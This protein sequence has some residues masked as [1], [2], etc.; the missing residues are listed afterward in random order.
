MIRKATPA[1]A[2]QCAKILDLAMD[3]ISGIIL[4]EKDYDK[5]IEK[6]EEFFR[7]RNNR[8]SYEN[9]IV[10][11]DEDKNICGAMIF[12]KGYDSDF[13]DAVFSERLKQLGSENL[14]VKE[15]EDDEFYIDSVAVD[16]KFRGKGYFKALM[17]E[18]INIAKKT[19][20]KKM[21]LVTHTPELYTRFGFKFDKNIDFYDDV[22]AKMIK[23]I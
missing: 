12:Y 3:D 22:Y 20:L 4:N 7:A 2:K 1:D 11:E 23:N 8:L 19:E 16:P 14:V 6:F 5:K 17:N 15:C 13:L 18:V 10:Y 21:S 9:V